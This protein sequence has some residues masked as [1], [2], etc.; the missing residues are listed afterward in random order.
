[1]GA[2]PIQLIGSGRVEL[3]AY[4]TADA[5]HRV[6]TDWSRLWPGTVLQITAVARTGSESRIVEHF[7]VAYRVRVELV[8]DSADSVVALRAAYRSARER[9]GGSRFHHMEW[10]PAPAT[11]AGA[12][13]G[14]A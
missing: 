13:E 7:T 1:M 2:R 6:E 3:A 10:S 4:G 11:P 5:E 12:G 8:V 14:T 9:I